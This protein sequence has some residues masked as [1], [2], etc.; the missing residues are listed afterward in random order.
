MHGLISKYKREVDAL[1][2]QRLAGRKVLPVYNGDHLA[3]AGGH[4]AASVNKTPE[5]TYTAYYAIRLFELWDDL[6]EELPEH[7]SLDPPRLKHAANRFEWYASKSLLDN[8]DR[9]WPSRRNTWVHEGEMPDA[10]TFA[11]L[12]ARVHR[13]LADI[14]ARFG[15]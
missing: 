14:Q 8:G 13:F 2:A 6:L 12:L 9:R 5:P 11:E 10:E 7:T 3:L 15:A 1:E 4:L